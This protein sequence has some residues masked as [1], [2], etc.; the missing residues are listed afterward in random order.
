[1]FSLC[2]DLILSL[3]RDAFLSEMMCYMMLGGWGFGKRALRVNMVQGLLRKQAGGS[4]AV[5]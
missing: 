3:Q 1:M 4:P 5:V 2:V